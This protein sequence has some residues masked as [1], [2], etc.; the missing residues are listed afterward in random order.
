MPMAAVECDIVLSPE[1]ITVGNI[2]DL[3]RLEPCGEG[4]PKPVFALVGATLQKKYALSQGKHTKLE[5]SYGGAVISAPM[6]GSAFD[7]FAYPEGAVLDVALNLEINSFNG[8][9]TVSS[10]VIDIRYHGLDQNKYFSAKDA[11]EKY[12]RGISLPKAFLKIVS[13]ITEWQN[14]NSQIVESP[15]TSESFGGYS[16]TKS[17]GSGSN[18]GGVLGWRDIFR[19]RL[20]AYRRIA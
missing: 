4:N 17:T 8:T 20:N 14:K 16:Y 5:L 3:L 19:A 12:K 6:F 18:A 9:E 13:D 1:D 2:K 15:Y 7:T 11:Y 10:R